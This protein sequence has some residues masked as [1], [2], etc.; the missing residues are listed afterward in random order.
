M[1][2]PRGNCE[3]VHRFENLSEEEREFFLDNIKQYQ[4]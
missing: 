4:I 3:E 2:C 1:K